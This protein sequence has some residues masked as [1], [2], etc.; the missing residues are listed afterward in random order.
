MRT[1]PTFI[2]TQFSPPHMVQNKLRDTD[3]KGKTAEL[4][5]KWGQAT[6]WGFITPNLWAAI[7]SKQHSTTDPTQRLI[8][9]LK[10]NIPMGFINTILGHRKKQVPPKP[11][12][13]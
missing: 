13:K 3:H 4:H 7:W 1:N 9:T 8:G 10:A 11:N 6:L 5:N 12:P 2:T